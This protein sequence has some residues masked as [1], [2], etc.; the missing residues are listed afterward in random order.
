MNILSDTDD[1]SEEEHLKLTEFEKTDLSNSHH[2]GEFFHFLGETFVFDTEGRL[3]YRHGIIYP[4][5]YTRIDP[6]LWEPETAVA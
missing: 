5:D 4:I 6:V 1:S 2:K 3:W